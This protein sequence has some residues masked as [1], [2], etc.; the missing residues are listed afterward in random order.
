MTGDETRGGGGGQMGQMGFEEMSLEPPDY[1]LHMSG[2]D[3]SG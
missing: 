1:I 3:L 2:H